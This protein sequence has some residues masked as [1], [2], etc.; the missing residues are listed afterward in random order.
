[1]DRI[2]DNKNIYVGGGRITTMYERFK[3]LEKEATALGIDVNKLFTDAPSMTTTHAKCQALTT[4]IS[5]RK[6][7]SKILENVDVNVVIG[8]TETS[9]S[10]RKALLK[11]LREDFNKQ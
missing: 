7:T 8:K 3:V 6:H 2:Q 1:M 10:E 4:L 5:E 9:A 11:K